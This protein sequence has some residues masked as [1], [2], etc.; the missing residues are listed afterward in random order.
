MFDSTISSITIEDLKDI[1]IEKY[2]DL[3]SNNYEKLLDILIKQNKSKYVKLLKNSSITVEKMILDKEYYISN[4]DIILIVGNFNMPM[5]LFSDNDIYE[6]ILT[7]SKSTNIYVTRKS[8]EYYF[9]FCKKNKKNIVNYKLVLL[10]NNNPKI[11]LSMLGGDFKEQIINNV[12]PNVFDL[13]IEN[14]PTKKN[15]KPRKIN[16]TT[17]LSK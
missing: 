16:V 12:K 11:G 10:E 13:L 2:K 14:I 6:S 17:R 15:T 9:I 5:V 1:L 3:Y 4:F 7:K 8:D